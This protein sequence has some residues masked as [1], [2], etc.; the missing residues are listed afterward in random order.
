MKHI[1]YLQDVCKSPALTLPGESNMSVA[2][3]TNAL[4][5]T[6]VLTTPA[7]KLVREFGLTEPHAVVVA[8]L[9]GFRRAE[10]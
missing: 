1:I 3:Q 9:A 2:A 5:W 8:D 7:R 6:R 10:R 4:N